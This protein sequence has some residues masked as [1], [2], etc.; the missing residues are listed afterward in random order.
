MTAR[1]NPH[2]TDDQIVAAYSEKLSAY[3]VADDL[4]VTPRCVYNVLARR[5]VHT[6]GL[7]EYRKNAERYPRDVQ[8]KIKCEYENGKPLEKLASEYGG[9]T[10]AVIHALRR[11][12]GKTRPPQGR[13]P[14]P[15]ADDQ[16][17]KACEMYISGM[18][19]MAIGAVLGY[20]QGVISRVLKE[21]GII[22]TRQLERWARKGG[23]R[24]CTRAPRS[25]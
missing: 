20:S 5:G 1:K 17:K 13:R 16:I 14:K 8:W 6:V 19:Q 12:G 7:N 3:K 2:I 21:G 23:R 4:G 9:S 11:M 18:S 24:I 25:R 15:I 10:Y 22:K